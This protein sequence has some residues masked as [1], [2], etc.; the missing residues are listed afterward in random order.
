MKGRIPMAIQPDMVGMVVRDM[1]ATLRFYRLLDLAIPDGVAD[2]PFV[3]VITP[4]GYRISWNTLEMIK[5]IDP[6]FVENPV[7]Q[8]I[9]L[10]FKCDSP[11]EVDAAYERIVAAGYS[12]HKAPWDAFWG[13]RYATVV[14]PDGNTVDLFA[15]L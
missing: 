10:A 4:N 12:S 11:A 14:D 7:G 1:E 15:A 8:R 6:D 3:E 13:Q 2:E 9:S 5:G